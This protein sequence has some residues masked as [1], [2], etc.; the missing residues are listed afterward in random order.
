[1]Q[2]NLWRLPGDLDA[3]AADV[4]WRAPDLVTPQFI[5]SLTDQEC[6]AC[7]NYSHRTVTIALRTRSVPLLRD[8][9]LARAITELRFSD[10][11]RCT[12][13]ELAP[14]HYVAEQLD[15]GAPALFAE[16]ADRIADEEMSELFR[17]FGLR[18][19]DVLRSF[20]WRTTPDPDG[21]DFLN[22]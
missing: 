12:L 17:G 3:M 15:I 21:T 6:R 16:I 8:A 10:D 13:H 2:P 1:M 7:G 19:G 4:V 20:N 22:V 11:W 18:T 14:Y 9:L 5:D